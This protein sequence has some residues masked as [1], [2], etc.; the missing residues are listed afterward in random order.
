[1]TDGEETRSWDARAST[2]V[3]GNVAKPRRKERG[4]DQR[5]RPL[6]AMA[7][8]AAQQ[9]QARLYGRSPGDVDECLVVLST[10]PDTF[11]L[12]LNQAAT[13]EA[14]ALS[15]KLA[16]QFGRVLAQT[17]HLTLH[18]AWLRGQSA[19]EATTPK[20]AVVA[21]LL[22]DAERNYRGQL[23]ASRSAC[24]A[25]RMADL[26]ELL[27]ETVSNASGGL[28]RLTTL[29]AQLPNDT[30]KQHALG[31]RVARLGRQSAMLVAGLV[32][33]C[34]RLSW[35][36]T[37]NTTAEIARSR[38]KLMRNEP[39]LR[40][41][42]AS[43]SPKAELGSQK[44]LCGYMEEVS[45]LA[46]PNT[47]LSKIKLANSNSEIHAHH[48]NLTRMGIQPHMRVWAQGKVEEVEGVRVLVAAFEGPGQHANEYW[49]DWLADQV[50][51]AYDLYPEVLFMDWEYPPAGSRGISKD[52]RVR[53]GRR[54]S[55]ED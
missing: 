36:R 15:R 3:L 46:R 7:R 6:L 5:L 44:R 2:R 47:P 12:L 8:R 17:V 55:E 51:S 31:L 14:H 13:D 22:R 34:A 24:R 16:K 30:R 32:L 54:A 50:R 26:L 40:G 35:E 49:E 29:I 53:L 42:L 4:L 11:E 10:V 33:L 23:F 37:R 1:M 20:V 43:L 39:R 18:H 25:G 19:T 41:T 38:N 21:R 52:L 45:W 28:A 9:A 48:K 27:D